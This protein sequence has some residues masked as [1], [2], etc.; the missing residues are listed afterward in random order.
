[1]K[2]YKLIIEKENIKEL[3]LYIKASKYQRALRTILDHL[4]SLSKYDD[5]DVVNIEEIRE[6]IKQ[7]LEDEG[8]SIEDLWE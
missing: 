8:V 1:M 6:T 3:D 7:F 4:R 5:M 2:M